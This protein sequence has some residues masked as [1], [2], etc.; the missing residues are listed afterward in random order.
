MTKQGVEIWSDDGLARCAWCLVDPVY[1]RYHDTEWGSPLHDDRRMF[2][3]L[4]L[5]GAQAGLSWL[6]ILRRREAYRRAYADWDAERVARFTQSDV[7]RLLAPDSG[8][9]RN[10]LKIESSVRNAQGFLKIQEEFESF[11]AFVW[12]FTE[13]RALVP[14]R[15]PQLLSE[16]PC[17]SAESRAL[18]R[19]L[20]R[21]DFKFVGPVI[22]YSFMQ[23]CGLV[24]D[25][26]EGCL[27]DP[28]RAR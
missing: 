2:E 8:V 11:D 13:G 25:H 20:R 5:E 7:E 15:A 9:I 26:L 10:R 12:R 22:M 16:V 14:S 27:L 3:M 17:E 28:R 6:T 21:R 1:V 4:T 19:E 23:A 24:N 18:S